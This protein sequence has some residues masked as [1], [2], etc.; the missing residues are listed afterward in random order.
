[1]EPLAGEFDLVDVALAAVSVAND[2]T[3]R[4]GDGAGD[5]APAT[6]FD[7][8]PDRVPTRGASAAPAKPARTPASRGPSSRR[9]GGEPEAGWTR[10]FVG[11]G[12]QAGMRPGDIVG[13]ITNEAGVAGSDVGAI[14]IA[15]G[16]SLVDVAAPVA[17]DV[18]RSLA[19]ASIRGRKV[20]VRRERDDAGPRAERRPRPARPPRRD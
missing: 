16:F 15:D 12:R 17:D 2:A 14:Q 10:L 7:A 11:A 20:A 18:V 9:P 1:V 13:A 5:I 3:S 19:G 8:R 6:L 4:D